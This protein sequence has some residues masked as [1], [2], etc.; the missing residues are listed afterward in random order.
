MEIFLSVLSAFLVTLTTVTLIR[1]VAWILDWRDSRKQ[2]AEIF[3]GH[4]EFMLKLTDSLTDKK[5]ESKHGALLHLRK[6][7][8]N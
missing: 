1:S 8:T 7:P 4:R 5:A 3:K 2:A 6:P